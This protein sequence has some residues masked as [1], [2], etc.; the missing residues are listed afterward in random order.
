MS[1]TAFPKPFDK[2]D[3][4]VFEGIYFKE[5]ISFSKGLR[6][7]HIPYVIIPRGSMTYQAMHN[8]AW[9]KKWIAHKLWFNSFI[10]HAWRIQYL[11]QQEADDST[12][13]FKTPYFIVPNGFNSPSVF[14]TSFCSKGVKALFIGR[15]DIYHKGI[16]LLLDAITL[17]HAEL[18]NAGF[19]LNI[20]GPKKYD[21]ERI[22]NEIEERGLNDVARVNDEISGKEKEQVILDSD[23]FIM[24]SR[25]E[26]H[27]MGLIEA[28]A[29]GLPCI[30]TPG[31]NMYEEVNK[32]D[33]GW[34]CE[35]K[36][37]SIKKALL[38]AIADKCLFGIKSQHAKELANRYNWDKLAA[39]F[40]NELMMLNNNKF[41]N[42]MLIEYGLLG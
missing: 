2:P 26:G 9:L 31:T 34:V 33:V 11:T 25:F 15:L 7:E 37:E 24:T 10:N 38:N 14:K 32:A 28:L 36:V 3:V 41:K 13:L 18:H 6:K 19:F 29:Y 5:Y 27:P 8:H 40:H 20:Y 4:V 35:G 1:L 17:V 23:I 21:Y 39:E 22:K 30:V 16:D 42:N 12:K